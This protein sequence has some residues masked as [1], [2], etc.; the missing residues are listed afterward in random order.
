MINIGFISL[1]IIIILVVFLILFFHGIKTS[2]RMLIS[3]IIA[4]YPS[5]V[6]FQNFPY[7][8]FDPGMPTAV[9][10]VFIYVATVF[11]LYKSISK[12]KVYTPLRKIIDYS[13]LTISYLALIIS[14]STNQI[15]SLQNLYTFSGFLPNLVNQIN[16][17]VILIIPLLVILI[18]AKSDKI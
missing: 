11:L 8:N 15:P 9:A 17:G 13:L 16:Y 1:D 4:M 10:F 6:I 14:V 3:L 2:K 7:V 18:T 12:K 5:L